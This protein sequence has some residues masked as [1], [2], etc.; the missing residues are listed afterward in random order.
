MQKMRTENGILWCIRA[1]FVIHSFQMS[2]SSLGNSAAFQIE[3]PAIL[4]YEN[5]ASDWHEARH[6][7]FRPNEW[8]KIFTRNKT[9]GNRTDTKVSDMVYCQL[10]ACYNASDGMHVD[11]SFRGISRAFNGISK[12]AVEVSYRAKMQPELEERLHYKLHI[13]E[14]DF[15]LGETNSLNILN[16]VQ[17]SK[18]TLLIIS[19]HFLKNKWCNF[20]INMATIE[21]IKSERGVVILVFLE[22]I[23]AV[24]MPKDLA[25]L[26]TQC[27]VVDWPQCED[28]AE[29]FWTKL[30]N[31]IDDYNDISEN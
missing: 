20:E 12:D 15:V 3:N 22:K 21:G 9:M 27:P 8:F 17:Q 6:L 2:S 13:R 5:R 29:A 7:P 26:L 25:A 18:R 1:V 28:V 16:A 23:P 4:D 19:R 31:N 14:R 10:C 11:C 24:F 30:V